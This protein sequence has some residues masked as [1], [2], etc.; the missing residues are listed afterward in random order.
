MAGW[1]FL[2]DSWTTWPVVGTQWLIKCVRAE[3][4]LQ[5]QFI[6]TN[7]FQPSKVH[8]YLKQ[9]VGFKEKLAVLLHITS[10]QPARAPELLSI[11]HVNTETNW[12]HNI[13]IENGLVI[14]VTAYHKSFYV[15]NDLKIINQY[16]PRE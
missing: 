2:L 13:F 12:H 9:V 16:V 5:S 11:Q 6:Q 4:G 8:A 3:P 15:T 10:G 14:L 7:S 1:S